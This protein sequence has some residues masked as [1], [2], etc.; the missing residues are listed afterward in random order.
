M[1]ACACNPTTK[2]VKAGRLL[3]S[4]TSY[5][6]SSKPMRNSLKK[7]GG[8]CPG[9]K[10]QG[11]PPDPQ[12]HTHTCTCVRPHTHQTKHLTLDE[13][14]TTH[15]RVLQQSVFLSFPAI[16]LAHELFLCPR[17]PQSSTWD[18][19]GPPGRHCR[20]RSWQEVPAVQV[21]KA[22]APAKQQRDR[23]FF[24]GTWAAEPRLGVVPPGRGGH[25]S[26]SCWDRTAQMSCFS[27]LGS[28]QAAKKLSNFLIFCLLS[29]KL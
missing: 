29:V 7:Q 11:C 13:N 3:A 12:T 28:L 10:T 19:P 21:Q 27:N 16:F 8:W 17:A 14:P 5:S 2:E 26:A 6:V 15:L 22:L 25:G 1:V 4:Q 23:P 9:D 24:T 20:D 18:I